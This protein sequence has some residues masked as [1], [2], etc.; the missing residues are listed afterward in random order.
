MSEALY[1]K[2][3]LPKCLGNLLNMNFEYLNIYEAKKLPSYHLFGSDPVRILYFTMSQKQTKLAKPNPKVPKVS[4]G[5]LS[6]D[7][8]SLLQVEQADPFMYY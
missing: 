5:L 7:L 2:I 4:L 3:C 6:S 8:L 1:E